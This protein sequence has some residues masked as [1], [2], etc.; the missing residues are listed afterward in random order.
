VLE[1]VSA[2][3]GSFA[4]NSMLTDWELVT[5]LLSAA[6]ALVFGALVAV[7]WPGRR[8]SPLSEKI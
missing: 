7:W 8:R 6:I 4:F 1:L 2:T 3:V 5:V